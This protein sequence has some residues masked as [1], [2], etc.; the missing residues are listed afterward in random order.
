MKEKIAN[1]SEKLVAEGKLFEAVE[2][3]KVRTLKNDEIQKE[4][5][6]LI[7]RIQNLRKQERLGLITDIDSRV[8]INRITYSFLGVLND[9]RGNVNKITAESALIDRAKLI[10]EEQ[11][12]IKATEKFKSDFSS[13]SIV[14][15]I[16]RNMFKEFPSK[17]EEFAN[18]TGLSLIYLTGTR[19]VFDSIVNFEAK[20]SVYL[21]WHRR[22]S[23]SLS[24]AELIFMLFDRPQTFNGQARF[25]EYEPKLI[26]KIAFEPTINKQLEIC[27]KNATYSFLLTNELY[28][29]IFELILTRLE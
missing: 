13:T 1:N 29:I 12:L 6:L 7:S 17:F 10:L 15:E 23:N 24:E 3:L 19:S 27:W 21:K 25:K 14:E 20:G 4:L 9:Y 28:N 16:V 8:E 18:N 22:Y 26:K 2:F 5:S 11:N